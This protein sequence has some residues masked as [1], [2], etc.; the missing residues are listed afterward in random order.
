MRPSGDRTSLTIT[1]GRPMV[2]AS[3][4]I[5]VMRGSGPSGWRPGARGRRIPHL[6]TVPP[7]RPM[8]GACRAAR[9]ESVRRLVG[10]YSRTP[11]RHGVKQPPRFATALLAGLGPQYEPLLGDLLEEFETW[12]SAWW[13]W[14]ETFGIGFVP[15]LMSPATGGHSVRP[16]HT[17][18]EYPVLGMAHSLN[19]RPHPNRSVAVCGGTEPFHQ[20][21]SL[22]Q[23]KPRAVAAENRSLKCAS[24][25]VSDA[26]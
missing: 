24:W 23:S 17:L 8:R 9:A 11:R 15:G 25:I 1:L 18:S 14:R 10:R 20:R 6:V 19:L 4:S 2:V 7:E 22:V 13:Y 3:R 26:G 5:R 12:Q 16:T 21:R